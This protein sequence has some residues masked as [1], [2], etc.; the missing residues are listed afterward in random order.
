MFTF[1][2]YYGKYGRAGQ[3][4]VENIIRLTLFACW[5]PKATHVYGKYIIFAAFRRQQWLRERPSMLVYTYIDLSCVLLILFLGFSCELLLC[6]RPI[7]VITWPS[8][9]FNCVL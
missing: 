2:R 4:A 3:A 8:D 7:G 5:I 6:G 1:M 9:L